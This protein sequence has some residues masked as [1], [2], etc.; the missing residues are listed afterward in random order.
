MGMIR[1]GADRNG[2][3]RNTDPN[4]KTELL[5]VDKLEDRMIWKEVEPKV[6]GLRNV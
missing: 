2:A 6:K 4:G 5:K 1:F 3:A